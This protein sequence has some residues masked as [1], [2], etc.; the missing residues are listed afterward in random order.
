[1]TVRKREAALQNFLRS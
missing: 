1:M